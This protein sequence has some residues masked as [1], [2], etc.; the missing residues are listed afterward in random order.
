VL[1]H[2]GW[3]T[4]PATNSSN[5]QVFVRFNNMGAVTTSPQE[6]E[7]GLVSGTAVYPTNSPTNGLVGT[8]TRLGVVNT[9]NSI[10]RFTSEYE[11]I[12]AAWQSNA[13]SNGFFHLIGVALRN[14]SGASVT[15]AYNANHAPVGIVE[16]RK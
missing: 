8:L 15:D 14:N 2:F 5:F 13:A 1:L 4:D 6:S 16:F 3:L 11:T 12:P 7:H 10:Y 9:T